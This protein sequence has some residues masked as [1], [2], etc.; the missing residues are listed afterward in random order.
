MFEVVEKFEK[1]IAKFY[2]APFAVATDS[3]THSIELGLRL[4][5]F[6]NISIPTRTYISIPFIPI[7]L[8]LKWKWDSTKWENFYFI[9]NTNIVDSAVYWKKNSYISDTIMCL[10]FQYQKHLNLG[11]GGMILCDNEKTYKSLK[12]MSYDGR[13]P[14]IPWREQNID[15][16]GF[17][18]YMT[19]ETAS[20]GLDKFKKEKNKL[21]R[22][23][24]WE[25][26]PDLSEMKIFQQNNFIN[27]Y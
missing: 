25:D 22:K 1:E 8:N 5:N 26:Y 16:L 6:D 12:K 27:K 17:H 10:S 23:W 9:G 15:T 18:Y 4:K 14:L 20:L 24:V 2:G 13:D 21:P 19:P 3:C 7:K 11:R